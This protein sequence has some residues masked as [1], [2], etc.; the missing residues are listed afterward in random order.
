M[1]F[2]V[3]GKIEVIL[4]LSPYID[5]VC[6]VAKPDHYFVVAL[7]VPNPIYLI[8]LAESLFIDT[9]DFESLC[10]NDTVM[11]GFLKQIRQHAT[12]SEYGSYVNLFL[13]VLLGDSPEACSMKHEAKMFR[14]F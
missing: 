9:S 13:F 2:I 1:S 7:I 14:G 5:N 4:R 11:D 3:A 6:V 8:K 12:R 10:Y